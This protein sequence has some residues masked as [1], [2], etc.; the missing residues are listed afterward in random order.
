MFL[1]C[2]LDIPN[3]L[4]HQRKLCTIDGEK[5]RFQVCFTPPDTRTGRSLLIKLRV[6]GKVRIQ[7][8]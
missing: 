1:K 2:T 6:T 7:P 8:K 4:S 3:L 5:D